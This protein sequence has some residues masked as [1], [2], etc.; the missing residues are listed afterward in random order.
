MYTV[1]TVYID[2]SIT[3]YICI[4]M[5]VYIYISIYRCR[6]IWCE[7][8]W[9]PALEVVTEAALDPSKARLTIRD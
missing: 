6:S 3:R 9:I 8:Y 2:I 7:V 5:R 4:Y 1:Y